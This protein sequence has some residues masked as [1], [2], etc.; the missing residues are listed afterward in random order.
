MNVLL[1][2]YICALWKKR[3]SLLSFFLRGQSNVHS[4]HHSK[5]TDRQRTPTKIDKNGAV[6]KG[7]ILVELGIL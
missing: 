4:W 3:A 6:A 2:V 1:N 7:R 5:V